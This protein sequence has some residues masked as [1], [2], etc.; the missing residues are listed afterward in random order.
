[1]AIYGIQENSRHTLTSNQSDI[2]N[3][4]FLFKRTWVLDNQRLD[5][6]SMSKTKKLLEQGERV[7]IWPDALKQYKDFNEMCVH[8]KLDEVSSKLIDDN[9]RCIKD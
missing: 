5:Q 1:M 4:K 8:F 6:A 3:S 9:T 2:L 7:F